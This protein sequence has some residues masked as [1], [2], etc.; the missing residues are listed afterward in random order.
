M[1]LLVIPK[2]I[3]PLVVQ[4]IRAARLPPSSIRWVTYRKNLIRLQTVIKRIFTTIFL[5]QTGSWIFVRKTQ[6]KLAIFA[7]RAIFRQH[8]NFFRNIAVARLYF[9]SFKD[10][11]QLNNHLVFDLTNVVS[12]IWLRQLIQLYISWEVLW[13]YY[14][15]DMSRTPDWAISSRLAT[16][17]WVVSSSRV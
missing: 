14:F 4:A 16:K 13:R 3:Q 2:R 1:G 7:T 6:K 12:V 15:S 8:L 10:L 11:Y 5:I 17:P 9:R